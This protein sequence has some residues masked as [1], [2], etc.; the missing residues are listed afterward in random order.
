MRIKSRTKH[1]IA[2]VPILSVLVL[3]ILFIHQYVAAQ[4]AGQG[5]EV[6]PPSQEVS[7]DP[8]KTVTVTAKIR[9]PGNN[10]LPIQVGIQDFTAQGEEGQVEITAN[11]PYS[12]TS[13]SKVSPNKFTLAPGEE[14]IVTATITAPSNAAGGHY[15][16]FVFS[17]SPDSQQKNAAAVTQELASLFLVRVSGPVNEKLTLKSLSAP[18]YS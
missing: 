3:C 9:N 4:V 10:T 16:S 7:V 2:I 1:W 17:V 6:S 8:G 15:G 5:L 14:Q 13:W 18:A 11:S 12:I